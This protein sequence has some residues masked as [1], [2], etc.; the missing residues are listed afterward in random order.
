LCDDRR[1]DLDV[2]RTFVAVVDEG[3]FQLAAARLALTQQAV[4]KRV[5]ALERELGVALLVRTPRGAR[6]TV[7]GQAFLPHARALLDA[8][9]RAAASV[10]PQQRALRVDMLSGRSAPAALLR[11]FHAA[12][13][14]VEIDLVTL[15]HAEQAIA[16]LQAGTIDATFRAVGPYLADDLAAARVCD[17]PIELLVGPRHPLAGVE[18]MAPA[19]LAAHPV[20]MPA[21]IGGTEWAAFYADFAAAFALSIDGSGPNFGTDAL[22]DAIAASDSLATFVGGDTRMIWPAGH[23]LRRVVLRDPMPVYPHALVWRR[24]D[25]NPAL[26]KL[27]RHLVGARPER[28]VATWTPA[29]AA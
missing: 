3:Q 23:D 29:W 21:L 10:R 27:R 7:D 5:A 9:S 14:D 22:Q 6:P 8:E 11:A 28:S 13:P 24:A 25:R 4:S 2:V 12:H 18:A 20:W 17:E 26:A 15:L 19:Q 16:A 1:V